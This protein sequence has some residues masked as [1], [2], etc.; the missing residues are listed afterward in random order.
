MS[1]K[2]HTDQAEP[3]GSVHAYHAPDS[4]TA[5]TA[6]LADGQGA[7]IAGGTDLVLQRRA[8]PSSWQPVLVS[9]RRIDALYG[10]RE[11]EGWLWLGPL[12]TVSELLLNPLV[13]RHAPVL[14]RAADC[15]ASSQV[16]N[17]AT[18]GGNLCNA[19][20]AGDLLV[21]LILLDA[22]VELCCFEDGVTRV[23]S[24]P[25]EQFLIGPGRTSRQPNEL[26]TAVRLPFSQGT[27]IFAFE[28][29]GTRPALD[30]ATVSVGLSAVRTGDC[31]TQVRVALGAV[32]PTALRAREVE[33]VLENRK[34]DD[35]TI[36][37]AASAAIEEINPIDDVRASSWY[38]KEL[39]HNLLM[40]VLRN[41]IDS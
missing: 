11:D 25:V 24:L 31:L 41:A 7:V 9:I 2:P 30:I 23:R 17:A 35:E 20:P 15:F 4:V 10:V 13:A 26:L 34:L 16:R 40:R 21:P 5:A 19:S 14:C 27:R 32:A 29:F 28:K 3:T 39:I 36:A 33:A 37:S 38:R 6:L 22:Q 8:A 12:T 18:L 1:S